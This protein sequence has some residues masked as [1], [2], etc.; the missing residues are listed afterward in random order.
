MDRCWAKSL[1]D[2]SNRISGEH[3][4]TA[5]LFEGDKLSI[6]GMEWCKTEV[7]E[8][9]KKSLVKNVLCTTHNSR[10]AIL[11]DEAIHAFKIFQDSVKLQQVRN[12]MKARYWTVEHWKIDG[13]LLERWFLKTLITLACEGEQKI[14]PDSGEV[15]QPTPSLVRIA[16]GLECQ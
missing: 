9:G 10:L 3:L 14:G 5:G 16:Y 13:P 6:Q 11:D 7:K 8:V 12:Q 4:F 2:C 15:G 1:G